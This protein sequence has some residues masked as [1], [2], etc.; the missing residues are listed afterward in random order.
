MTD[1]VEFIYFF[2]AALFTVLTCHGCCVVHGSVWIMLFMD[3]S[4]I[5]LFMLF[6][7]VHGSVCSFCVRLWGGPARCACQRCLAPD[8]LSERLQV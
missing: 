8:E 2:S 4:W 1:C 5:M 7:H 3:G 6:I